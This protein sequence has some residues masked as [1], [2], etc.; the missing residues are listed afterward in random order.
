MILITCNVLSFPIQF[1]PLIAVLLI[2]WMYKPPRKYTKEIVWLFV[3]FGL[4]KL[5]ESL[6][7]EVCQLLGSTVSDHLLKYLLMAL[8]GYEIIELFK[9]CAKFYSNRGMSR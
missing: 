3:F 2:L 7:K 1:F 6:D 9:G 5:A 8:G 4:A